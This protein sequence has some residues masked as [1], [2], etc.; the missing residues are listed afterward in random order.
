MQTLPSFFLHFILSACAALDDKRVAVSRAKLHTRR[1][2]GKVP[3]RRRALCQEKR[4]QPTLLRAD[5][6]ATV[7]FFSGWLLCRDIFK[8]M[9]NGKILGKGGQVSY[10]FPFHPLT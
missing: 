9:A 2:V 5:Q 3:P 8:E 10:K 1:L 4:N 7:V 6:V